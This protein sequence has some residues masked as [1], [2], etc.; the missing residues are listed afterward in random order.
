[1][2]PKLRCSQPFIDET[3]GHLRAGGSNNCET[4]VLWLGILCD[5]T[6]EVR[7]VHRP[8]Q[9]VDTDFFLIPQEG[10]RAMMRRLT[11]TRFQILA[12]V[13]SHPK[14]AFH[15]ST[16]DTCAIIRHVGAVSIVIP[17]FAVG[18][19]STNFGNRA[20]TYQLDASDRWVAVDF[21]ATV[22]VI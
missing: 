8:E 2:I 21:A 11:E 9:S 13:H 22:E 14:A 15:S 10:V 6:A 17:N 4:V 18:T 12:Q 20:A 16:D 3:L 7:E 1:V 19:D 5:G